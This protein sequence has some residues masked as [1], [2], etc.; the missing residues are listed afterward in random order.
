MILKELGERMKAERIRQKMTQEQ[1]AVNS[2]VGKSTVERAENGE[3]VQLLNLVKLLRTLHQLSSLDVLLPSAEMTPMQYLYSK[4]QRPP[5]RYRAVSEKKV[6]YG[7]SGAAPRGAG[8][9]SA[10]ERGAPV[11][12][13]QGFVWEEDK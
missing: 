5:E 2:G 8:A 9:G 13:L 12:P 10:G 11:P 1:F 4:T 3:S 7:A 6:S